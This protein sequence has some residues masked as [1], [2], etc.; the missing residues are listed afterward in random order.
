MK[1][2]LNIVCVIVYCFK[3]IIMDELM[4][5]IDFQFWN[6]ILI[7]VK[8]LN[9]MGSIIIYMSYY[10][11]EVE[12]VCIKIVIIDYGK[13]IVEGIKEQLKVIIID[14]KDIWIEVKEVD[15]I[16]C[17]GLKE[18]LGVIVVMYE[19]GII[20][21]NLS[22]EVNN[23]NKVIYYLMIYYIEIKVVKE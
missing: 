16:D 19:D 15:D 11:E 4:V 8:K 22:V 1:R 12:E 21:I 10:M 17:S 18:I 14:I 5:G 23:L 20:K 2:R 9:E 6:Y 7:F 3:F 13:I